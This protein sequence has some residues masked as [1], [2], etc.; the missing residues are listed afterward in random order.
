MISGKLV[1]STVNVEAEIRLEY[2]GS[3]L[4][5]FDTVRRD[6]EEYFFPNPD[7]NPGPVDPSNPG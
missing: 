5:D 3:I 6:A 2:G 7:P 4:Y 1:D